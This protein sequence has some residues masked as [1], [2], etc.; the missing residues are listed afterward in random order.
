[1]KPAHQTQ[2]HKRH[3][4]DDKHRVGVSDFVLLSDLTESAVVDNLKLRFEHD[5]IYTSIVDVL[6]A[7]NPYRPLPIYSESVIKQYRGS[8]IYD[9]PP[10]M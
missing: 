5:E 6:V 3:E 8:Q 4:H 9:F 7:V 1:M 10:H 2:A